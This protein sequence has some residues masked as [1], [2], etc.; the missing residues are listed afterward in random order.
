MA[1][2]NLLK[3]FRNETEGNVSIMFAM[4]F[5]ATFLMIGAAFDLVLLN[6][7]EENIQY[8]ADAAAL[9]ALQFD[10]DVK[11]KEDAFVRQMD[12]LARI[13]GHTAGVET[14]NV[15][16]NQNQSAFTLSATVNVPHDLI[17]LQNIDGFESVSVSTQAVMGTEDV[18]IAL[19]LDISAS[20]RGSKIIEAQKAAKLF[21]NDLLRD[22]NLDGRVSVSLI[23]FGGTVRVPAD[24]INLLDVPS[25]GLESYADK[26]I[27]GEWNQCFEFDASDIEDGMDPNGL[28][29][30]IP[31]FVAYQY[32]YPWC[33][34]EGNEMVPLTNDANFLEDK[35]DSFT[36]SDGTGSDHGMAWAYATLNNKWKNKFPGGLKDTPARNNAGTRKIIVFMTDGGITEQRFVKDKDL[37]GKPPFDG[38]GR[39]RVPLADARAALFSICDEAKEN[40]IEIY[41]IGY[42]LKNNT[43][44]TQLEYCATSTSHNY[45]SDS[46]ELE[47]VFSGLA[48][49][50][51]PLR[52]SR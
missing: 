38:D 26:W 39:N 15:I 7:S 51:S 5:T 21:I 33:P 11:A 18:E 44:R 24:L 30:A 41:T 20:M 1:D 31:D 2:F 37:T 22:E 13:S 16:V 4:S 32:R 8:L 29:R 25:E 42:D 48:A 34:I 52:T 46:G 9:S 28:Y 35:I 47:N 50:I 36:L 49:S 6:K 43:Q 23:P 3:R 14:T 10:G 27:D 12:T 17:M 45:S 19:A 40:E